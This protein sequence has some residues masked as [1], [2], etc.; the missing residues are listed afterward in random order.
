[1]SVLDATLPC[2]SVGRALHSSP[3]WNSL[4]LTMVADLVLRA[5][6][7]LA[8][9]SWRAFL[10]SP[11][12]RSPCP[13]PIFSP[14]R[15]DLAVVLVIDATQ[16][17]TCCYPRGHRFTPSLYFHHP[18]RRSGDVLAAAPTSSTSPQS[19]ML[20]LSACYS[21]ALLAST[22]LSPVSS[23]VVDAQVEDTPPSIHVFVLWVMLLLGVTTGRVRDPVS[24]C[25]LSASCV[26]IECQ[27]YGER[28]APAHQM[29]GVP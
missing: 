4:L 27:D 21:S 12:L 6:R 11:W 24:L 28:K 26:R 23:P 29:S 22:T 17:S 15:A 1:M 10:S 3:P 25:S 19:S 5:P 2:S 13:P 16:S 18:W 14:S 20:G 9:V 8:A 7:A